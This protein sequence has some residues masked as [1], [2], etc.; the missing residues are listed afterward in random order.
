MICLIICF[1]LYH[2]NSESEVQLISLLP[3]AQV[4][5]HTDLLLILKVR[6]ISVKC[7]VAHEVMFQA[8]LKM[9]V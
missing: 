1:S 7:S 8:H 4:S 6:N 5:S 2:L 9:V 3:G